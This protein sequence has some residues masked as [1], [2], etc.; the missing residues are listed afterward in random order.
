MRVD[1]L[2]VP[3]RSAARVATIGAAK[4]LHPVYRVFN[5]RRDANHRYLTSIATRSAMQAAGGI[6][7]G[8]APGAVAMRAIATPP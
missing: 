3:A 5:A 6:P 7:E 4:P 8:Y 1:A 2:T